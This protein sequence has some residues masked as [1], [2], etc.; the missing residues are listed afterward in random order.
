[1]KDDVDFQEWAGLDTE[2]AQDEAEEAFDE[3]FGGEEEANLDAGED[4]GPTEEDRQKADAAF[5]ELFNP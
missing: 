3:V 4:D 2:D 5:E 1:M